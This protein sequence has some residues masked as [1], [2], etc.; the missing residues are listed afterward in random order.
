MIQYSTTK[1]KAKMVN[2]LSDELLIIDLFIDL[3]SKY[4]TNLKHQYTRDNVSVV[5][6]HSALKCSALKELRLF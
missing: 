5:G 3:F 1:Y 2:M 6:Q 4:I